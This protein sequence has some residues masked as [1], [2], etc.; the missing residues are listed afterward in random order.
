[1]NAGATMRSFLKVLFFLSLPIGFVS[2]VT[3]LGFMVMEVPAPPGMYGQMPYGHAP[4]QG[5]DPQ[6]YGPPQVMLRRRILK[7]S[8]QPLAHVLPNC[9]A[10]GR[11]GRT[12]AGRVRRPGAGRLKR[13]SRRPSFLGHAA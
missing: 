1:M 6:G 4:P 10:A 7:H 9:P 12:T 11:P 13:P 8:H 5:Y 2:V 3:L